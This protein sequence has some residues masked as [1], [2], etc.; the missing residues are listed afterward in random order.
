M[1]VDEITV[2]SPDC[3]AGLTFGPVTLEDVWEGS[4]DLSDELPIALTPR[5]RQFLGIRW[6][7]ETYRTR[8][9]FSVTRDRIMLRPTAPVLIER[10]T[11]W[12]RFGYWLLAHWRPR[13]Q[14]AREHS[15][16]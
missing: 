6:Y 4:G 9:V 12:R 10:A 16:I 1:E 2:P 7:P 15:T 3:P 13:R 8:G 5:C 11:W 14:R